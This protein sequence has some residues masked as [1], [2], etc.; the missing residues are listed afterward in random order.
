LFKNIGIGRNYDTSSAGGLPALFVL[1]GSRRDVIDTTTRGGVLYLSFLNTRKQLLWQK[2]VPFSFVNNV[3][4][5]N[6][7]GSGNARIAALGTVLQSK[8]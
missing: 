1:K 7:A 8:P 3:A 6:H 2:R 4:T 5:N